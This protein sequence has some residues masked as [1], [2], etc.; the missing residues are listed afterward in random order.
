[1]LLLLPLVLPLLPVL[2]VLLLAGA[3]CLLVL[4]GACC[5]QLHSKTPDYTWLTVA[6]AS[7]PGVVTTAVEEEEG[8]GGFALELLPETSSAE[9]A[10]AAAWCGH[11]HNMDCHPTQWP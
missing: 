7:P 3:C 1:M 2:P 6:S 10:A 8:C 9:T 11:P 4:A 5:L